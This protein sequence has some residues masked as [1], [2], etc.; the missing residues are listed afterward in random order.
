MKIE[1]IAIWASDIE[2]MREF[3]QKYFNMSCG[4]KYE[5]ELA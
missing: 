2:R 3:Y 5:V 4:K 1:H